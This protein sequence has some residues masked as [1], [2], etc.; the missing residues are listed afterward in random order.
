MW[1]QCLVETIIIFSPASRRWSLK[2]PHHVEA[3]SDML[4]CVQASPAGLGEKKRLAVIC[5]QKLENV[6][7][8]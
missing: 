6:G 2:R 4:G 3:L 7:R 1:P 8:V 5:M